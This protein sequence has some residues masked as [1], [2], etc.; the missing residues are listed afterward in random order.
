MLAIPLEERGL[1]QTFGADYVRYRERVR[2][3]MIPGLY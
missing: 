1:V 3:R 2:Y